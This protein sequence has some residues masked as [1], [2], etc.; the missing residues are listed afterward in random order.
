MHT[1]EEFKELLGAEADK[2]NEAQLDQL[3]HD[4]Y[5]LADILIDVHLGQRKRRGV[6]SRPAGRNMKPERSTNNSTLG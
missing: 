2:Y 3:Q 5:A 4:M 6:D 1:I